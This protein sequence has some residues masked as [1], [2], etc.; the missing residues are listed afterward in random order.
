MTEVT[1]GSAAFARH[2]ALLKS[3]L[4]GVAVAFT[5]AAAAAFVSDSYGGPVMLYAL[6]LGIGLSFLSASEQCAPGLKFSTKFILRAGIAL[7]G[8]RIAVSDIVNLGVSTAGI[9]V[10]CV[11]VTICAG[12]LLARALSQ[13]ASFGVLVGGATA[14]CGASAALAISSVLP[15]REDLERNAVFTVVA[16]TSLSTLAMV[17]YP[18][19]FVALGFGDREVG[20]LLGA[21]IHDVAQVVGAGYLVSVEAGDAATI[22]KLFRVALLLPTVVVISLVFRRGNTAGVPSGPP[23]PVFVMVFAAL[24]GINSLGIVPTIVHELLG[25]VSRA[26]LIGAVAAIGLSSSLKDLLRYGGKPMGLAL[27]VTLILL[28]FAT[29]VSLWAL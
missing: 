5:A 9:V 29:L 11:I 16:V 21:T 14:I 7:L 22:V 4:P 1:L 20:I 28:G 13:S 23:V 19:I 17:A 3:R 18:A 24:A 25:A 27:G 8:L 2:L 15:Q 6:I 26:C 12:V 10:A